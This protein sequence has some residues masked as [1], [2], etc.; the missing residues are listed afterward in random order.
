MNEWAAQHSTIAASLVE[1]TSG[2]ALAVWADANGARLSAGP[3][4]LLP[5]QRG[6]GVDVHREVLLRG[7]YGFAIPPPI[8]QI[9]LTKHTVFAWAGA[10]R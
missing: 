9:D 1:K 2:E 10:V 8:A 5:G 3:H 7:W 4:G 6:R